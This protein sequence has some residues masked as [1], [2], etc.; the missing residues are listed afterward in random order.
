MEQIN[1][2]PYHHFNYFDVEH[3]AHAEFRE[4][5]EKVRMT[6]W[7]Y[8]LF[9]LSFD[10]VHFSA[11]P[12]PDLTYR[13]GYNQI[14]GDVAFRLSQTLEGWM[15]ILQQAPEDLRIHC[16]FSLDFQE[17][18][19]VRVERDTLISDIDKI[20]GW[21]ALAVDRGVLIHAGI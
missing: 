7:V 6:D 21:A 4:A 16:G 10:W 9:T 11:R 12:D 17:S 20:R 13:Y 2:G 1:N 19:F 15:Q 14:S 5:P 8:G 3:V 18:L